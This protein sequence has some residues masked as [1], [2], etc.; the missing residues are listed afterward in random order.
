M[1]TLEVVAKA[2]YPLKFYSGSS[3]CSAA[4]WIIS[5]LRRSRKNDTAPAPELFFHEHDSSSGTVGFH[6]CGSGSWDLCFHGSSSGL[7]WFSHINILIVL[8]CLKLN[9]K[10]I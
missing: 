10:R 4:V 1:I 2:I 9:G 6:E 8:V 3:M 5:G 7:W